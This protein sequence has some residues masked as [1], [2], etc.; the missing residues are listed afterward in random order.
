MY[1]YLRN[2]VYINRITCCMNIYNTELLLFFFFR[3]V[4]EKAQVMAHSAR[5]DIFILIQILQFLWH[6]IK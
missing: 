1:V 2:P 4:E 3:I 6:Y 5:E